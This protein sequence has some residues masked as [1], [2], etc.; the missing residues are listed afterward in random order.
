MGFLL[1]HSHQSKSKELFAIKV[2]TIPDF[3]SPSIQS[4]FNHV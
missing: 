2:Q 1:N 4:E 3:T